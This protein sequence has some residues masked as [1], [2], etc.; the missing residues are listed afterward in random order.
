VTANSLARLAYGNETTASFIP[1]LSTDAACSTVES[2]T[3]ILG[4][5]AAA[6]AKLGL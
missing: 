3:T 4:E 2:V 6:L 5:L 1:N